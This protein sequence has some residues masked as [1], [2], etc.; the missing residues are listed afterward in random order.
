MSA[1]ASAYKALTSDRALRPNEAAQLLAELRVENGKELADAVERDLSGKY[2]RTATDTEAS[3]RRK[4]RE[5]GAAMRVVNAFRH[6]AA[7]PFRPALPPQRNRST[8]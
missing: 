3:F 6:L 2:R 7:A 1:Y 8:S 5:Y 4:R